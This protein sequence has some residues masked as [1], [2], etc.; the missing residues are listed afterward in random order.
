MNILNEL[1][2]DIQNIILSK[3]RNPQNKELLEDIKNF[4]NN[5]DII[6]KIYEKN[7]Y[8]YKCDYSN[9]FNIYSIIDNDLMAYWNDDV[10]YMNGITEKNYNKMF[11]ILSFKLKHD[12]N[13]E[14]S[15]YNFHM[16]YKIQ[17]KSKINK[18]IGGLNVNE[19]NG[20]INLLKNI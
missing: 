15:I 18:Y 10:A 5:K 7:G 13:N 14:K 3:I 11:R 9:E 12:L 4:K 6:F 17:L 16:N 8:E 20:F 1:P 19:R 2:Y